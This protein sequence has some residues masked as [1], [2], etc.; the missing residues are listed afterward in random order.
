M[1]LL[2]A[3]IYLAFISLGLPDAVLGASWPMMS[4]SLEASLSTAGFISL[5]VSL[6][7]VLSSLMT[8]RLIA[9]LG[10]GRV[11][12]F[13]VLLTAIALLG[14]AHSHFVFVMV[15]LAIPLGIGAGAVDA[16]LNNFVALH[17]RS[18]HMNFLH[19]FWGVGATAGPLIMANFLLLQDGWRIGYS[20]IAYTQFGLVLVLLLALPLWGKAIGRSSTASNEEPQMNNRAAFKL[21]HVK[22]QM[23]LFF[24][25]CSVELGT[26][27]W[28]AS[29]L[30][31]ERQVSAA[32]AAF[33]VAVYYSGITLGRFICGAISHRISE[34]TLIRIGVSF[35]LLGALV[36]VLPMAGI[37]S[38]FGL[39]L[40]GLGCAPVYPNTIHLT[41]V[42][43]GSQASQAIIGLSMAMAYVGNTIVPPSLGLFLQHISF[44]WFP[45][46]ILLFAIGLWFCTERLNRVHLNLA[47]VV[48]KTA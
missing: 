10:V 48:T 31:I 40:I 32:D 24:C 36:L 16:A 19:S 25:Y 39:L 44:A 21:P 18:K 41:P 12:V 33:W 17:Y 35:M 45:Y 28:S 47:S 6:G 9:W 2:L 11:V 27:L 20:V 23:M 26:G 8:S 37:L 14:I 15:L 38:K 5:V 43:F 13:S 1:L 30:I 34:V 46:L 7:T 29:F 4:Q 3:I 42:R 22:V